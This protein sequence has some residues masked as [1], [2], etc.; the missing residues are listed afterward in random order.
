[1]GRK[2]FEA[3]I[4]FDQWPYKDTRLIVLTSKNL[5]IPEKLNKTVTASNISSPEQLFKELDGQS[6]NHIYVD[7]GIAIHDFL[8]AGLVDEITV[9]IVPILIGKGKSFSGLLPKDLSLQ[10]L[11]TIVYDFGFVQNKCKINK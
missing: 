6:I 8:S 5:Q 4:S 9:T 11:K 2:T 10:H 1:M 3:V 7:G